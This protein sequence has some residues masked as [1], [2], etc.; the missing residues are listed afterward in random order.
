[1]ILASACATGAALFVVGGLSHMGNVTVGEAIAQATCLR[2][3]AICFPQ[4]ATF[5]YALTALGTV[6]VASSAVLVLAS[7]R[8]ASQETPDN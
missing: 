1:M 7:R 8:G 4:A 3:T 5:I 6:L 2:S